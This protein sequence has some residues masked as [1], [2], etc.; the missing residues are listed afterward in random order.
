MKLN[1]GTAQEHTHRMLVQSQG[2]RGVLARR[3][4]G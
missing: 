2:I 3:L 1:V 4:K